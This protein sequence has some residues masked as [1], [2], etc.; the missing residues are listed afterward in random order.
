MVN[1]RVIRR[2]W[3]L[4]G[5][6]K[7]SRK[8]NDALDVLVEAEWLKPTTFREGGMP[9]RLKEDFSVNPKIWEASDEPMA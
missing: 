7:D 5:I 1:V 9:G 3:A 4:P 6:N 8:V 2:E